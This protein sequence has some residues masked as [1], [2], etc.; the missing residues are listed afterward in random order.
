MLLGDIDAAAALVTDYKAPELTVNGWPLHESQ[1][2]LDVLAGELAAALGAVER[3]GALEYNNEELWLW[4]AE[5]GAA[6]DLWSGRAQSARDRIA[7]VMARIQPSP[8]AARAGRML[9]F[10][11]WAAA[12]LADADPALDREQL[13]RQL[14]QWADGAECV[15]A[16]PGRVLGSAYGA[17]F[18]GEIARLRHTNEEAAWRAAKDTWAS[19]NVPHHTAYA[20][21]RLAE[22]L[23]ADG[24]RRDAES[25]LASASLAA[26][27]HVPLRREIEGLARRARLALPDT[28]PAA[29]AEEAEPTRDATRGLTPRELDVL[30][31]LGSGAT[32]AEIGRRLYMSPKTASVHVTAILRKLGVTGRVQAATVAERMGLLAPENESSRNP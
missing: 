11:A 6:A 13:A 26:E 14:Q 18:D 10:A 23:L 5:I 22:R 9:A 7:P 4:L 25:E 21:W 8:R 1:A 28:D 30:R 31:L 3:L 20:G 24:R 27:N 16:H 32:N 29:P 19:H 17:T 15:G 2:E 12:D